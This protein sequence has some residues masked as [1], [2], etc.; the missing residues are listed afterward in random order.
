MKT[1]HGFEYFIEN[2]KFTVNFYDTFDSLEE[3]EADIDWQMLWSRGLAV[4]NES[5]WE[6]VA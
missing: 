2:G 6:L 5:G 1:R 3:L 4:K